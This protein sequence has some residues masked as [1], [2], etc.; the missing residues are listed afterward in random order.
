MVGMQQIRVCYKRWNKIY[1]IWDINMKVIHKLFHRMMNR[2]WKFQGRSLIYMGMVK[3][4]DI[5]VLLLTVGIIEKNKLNWIT[6]KI[7]CRYVL[8]TI[9]NCSVLNDEKNLYGQQ[10]RLDSKNIYMQIEKNLLSCCIRVFGHL[11]QN[12]LHWRI[13]QNLLHFWVRHSLS[14][15]GL[16]VITLLHQ[17]LSVTIKSFL[18]IKTCFWKKVIFS[19]YYH[20]YYFMCVESWKM[21][22][23]KV[24]LLCK[25]SSIYQL[26]TALFESISSAFWY[27]TEAFVG[28]FIPNKI[29]PFLRYPFTVEKKKNHIF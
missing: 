6:K 7:V 24:Q 2:L 14:L 8:H 12:H 25:Y 4:L 23:L 11:L 26:L 3:H 9:D 15:D 22:V 13:C 5:P 20:I 28:S 18:E 17:R 29:P 10:Q 21:N 27:A 19:R 16:W 1:T